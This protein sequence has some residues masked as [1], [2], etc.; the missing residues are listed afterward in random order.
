MKP[1]NN[2]DNKVVFFKMKVM[3]KRIFKKRWTSLELID[4]LNGPEVKE[5]F[6]SHGGHL[7]EELQR[8]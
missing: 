3:V 2:N 6:L 1:T 8:L 7:F 4:H 5:M